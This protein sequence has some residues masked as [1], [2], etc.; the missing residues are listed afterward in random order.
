MLARITR[1]LAPVLLVAVMAAGLYGFSRLT[2]DPE[3]RVRNAELAAELGQIHARN[4]RLQTQVEGLRGEI[5][6]LRDG[7]DESLYHARTGL[8]LVRPGE[9]VYQFEQPPEGTSHR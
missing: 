9:V 3:L 1:T 8:G 2:V 7:D 4:A 5:R 6:R